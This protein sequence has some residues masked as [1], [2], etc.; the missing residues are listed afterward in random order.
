MTFTDYA[1]NDLYQP[2]PA[3]IGQGVLG[4]QANLVEQ[5][6]ELSEFLRVALIEGRKEARA[7]NLYPDPTVV[8]HEDTVRYANM[9]LAET[10]DGGLNYE[11][12]VALLE[13]IDAEEGVDYA[14]ESIG[15]PSTRANLKTGLA[16]ANPVP[17]ALGTVL[18]MFGH[19][20]NLLGYDKKTDHHEQAMS[21]VKTYPSNPFTTGNFKE[22]TGMSTWEDVAFAALDVI[23]IASI[24]LGPQI[25]KAVREGLK[26]T[27][28]RTNN[29]PLLTAMDD[30]VELPSLAPTRTVNGIKISDPLYS[31]KEGVGKL[32]V[33][34]TSADRPFV[35]V[36]YPDGNTELW[37][38]SSGQN[39]IGFEGQWFPFEGFGSSARNESWYRKLAGHPEVQPGMDFNTGR[40]IK[41]W[42][43][44][45][46]QEEVQKILGDTLKRVKP[47][48]VSL[49]GDDLN[50]YLGVPSIKEYDEIAM[51]RGRLAHEQEMQFQRPVWYG[52]DSLNKLVKETKPVLPEGPTQ[53]HRELEELYK[54]PYMIEGGGRLGRMKR[55]EVVLSQSERAKDPVHY[56]EMADNPTEDKFFDAFAESYDGNYPT[57]WVRLDLL[58]DFGHGTAI[59]EARIAQLAHMTSTTSKEIPALYHGTPVEFSEIRLGSAGARHKGE[60]R[61][62]GGASGVGEFE[63]RI[64][65]HGIYTVSEPKVARG[66]ATNH[67]MGPRGHVPE[68]GYVHSLKWAG[69]DPR[70]LDILAPIPDNL[71][72]MWEHNLSDMTLDPT[73]EI[74]RRNLLYKL[75]DPDMTPMEFLWGIN[76]FGTFADSVTDL[77]KASVRASYKLEGANSRGAVLHDEIFAPFH[78]SMQS[79]YDV[80]LQPG[81]GPNWGLSEGRGA[82]VYVW[83]NPENLKTQATASLRKSEDIVYNYNTKASYAA[84]DTP[85]HELGF[86]FEIVPDGAELGLRS[87]KLEFKN[88][89]YFAEDQL[90]HSGHTAGATKSQLQDWGYDSLIVGNKV[91]VFDPKQISPLDRMTPSGLRPKRSPMSDWSY[92]DMQIYLQHGIEP[93]AKHVGFN[94]KEPEL[95]G[96]RGWFEEHRS[97][98]HDLTLGNITSQENLADYGQRIKNLSNPELFKLDTISDS[99]LQKIPELD[100]LLTKA[101]GQYDLDTETM[102]G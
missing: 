19:G 35:K 69:D 102:L 43:P 95:F 42:E 29:R 20:A 49:Q 45:G 65:G 54:E 100:D 94:I 55:E 24:L 16:M 21:R 37:Y 48:K 84:Y 51:N 8:P 72:K 53:A 91:Y 36:T 27:A 59:N 78:K 23:D 92:E 97:I 99:N 4:V 46:R 60:G 7:D 75:N 13:G 87:A 22:F 12:L 28:V 63:S 61:Y 33:G 81:S 5:A 68:Y 73:I 77:T 3:E 11:N 50:E 52:D 62:W 39:A 80:L 30:I 90:T 34:V 57:I 66:Y 2:S 89:A 41:E 88:P 26:T 98:A 32:D 14:W 25:V 93:A 74:K 67:P 44:V 17:Q 85:N 56:Y 86:E 1:Q 15:K 96:E 79:E 10:T 71:R 70:V 58:D 40:I 83:I 82:S 6:G 31:F 38:Q 47:K 9:W 18:D 101:K 64:L 76:E